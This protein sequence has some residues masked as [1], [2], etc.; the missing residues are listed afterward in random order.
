MHLLRSIFLIVALLAQAWPVTVAL[1]AN[2]TT[3]CPMSCCAESDEGCA[4]L[5]ET[6]APRLPAPANTP[7]A[8]GREL[9]PQVAVI[10]LPEGHLLRSMGGI[11]SSALKLVLD[12]RHDKRGLPRLTVLHCSFLI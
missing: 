5:A 9:V 11:E 7:P 2:A 4:C 1:G 10:V 6:D 8:T 3:K 12:D